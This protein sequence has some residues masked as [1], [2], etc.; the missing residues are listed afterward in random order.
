MAWEGSAKA[1]DLDRAF[2]GWVLEVTRGRKPG[3]LPVSQPSKRQ[4]TRT[5]L[6]RT[7]V[8]KSVKPQPDG[9]MPDK[10]KAL[11]EYAADKFESDFARVR[12]DQI[13]CEA[14]DDGVLLLRGPNKWFSDHFDNNY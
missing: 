11:R 2:V 5:T 14:H 3:D 13:C 9:A 8:N 12:T 6:P 7:E 10:T 1:V 4:S